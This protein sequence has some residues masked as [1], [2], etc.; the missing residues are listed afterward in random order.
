MNRVH[1]WVT[2]IINPRRKGASYICLCICD[3]VHS[4]F[5]ISNLVFSFQGFYPKYT[6]LYI[7]QNLPGPKFSTRSHHGRLLGLHLPLTLQLRQN[8]LESKIFTNITCSVHRTK[9]TQ[10]KIFDPI[11]SWPATWTTPS[12]NFTTT[13]KRP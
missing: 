2:G 5:G 13:S 9:L 8:D 3:T 12:P 4:A 1:A 11:T 6:V 7:V 10:T